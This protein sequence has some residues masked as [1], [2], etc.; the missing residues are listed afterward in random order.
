MRPADTQMCVDD[1]R[2]NLRSFIR[3]SNRIEGIIREPIDEEISAT[4]AFIALAKITMGDMENL[5]NAYQPGA[6]LRIESG[7]N[8]R[9]GHHVAPLGGECVGVI[10]EGILAKANGSGWTAYQVHQEYEH[11]HPF[12][13]GNG[14]SG[15]TLWLWMMLSRGQDVSLGFL[16]HWYYQSLQAQR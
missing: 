9:V 14:R 5:V 8:V 11:L 3:E 15:R 12:M 13:D 1:T 10:L 4:N 2:F 7:M 6:T 16:H